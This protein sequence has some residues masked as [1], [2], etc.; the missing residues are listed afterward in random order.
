[1]TMET[2]VRERRRFFE[3]PG[4]PR[5][6][7]VPRTVFAGTLAVSSSAHVF[8]QSTKRAAPSPRPPSSQLA[9]LDQG[10]RPGQR[11]EQDWDMAGRVVCMYDGRRPH[12]SLDGMTP[13]RAYFNSLL[14]RV[15][16]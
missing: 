11:V 10:H 2:G 14:L 7:Q 8:V 6:M 9:V 4:E 16:A 15:P 13:D 3:R 12:T 5:P 1:M